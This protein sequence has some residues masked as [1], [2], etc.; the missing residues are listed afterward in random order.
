MADAELRSRMGRVAHAY[1]KANFGI[2]LM[3]DGMEAVFA[4][5]VEEAR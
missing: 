1:A 2:D 4:Q 3:L 5:A